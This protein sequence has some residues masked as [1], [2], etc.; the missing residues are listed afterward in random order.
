MVVAFNDTPWGFLEVSRRYVLS[1]CKALYQI[2]VQF[3]ESF[4]EA[5]PINPL[6]ALSIPGLAFSTWRTVQLPKLHNDNL[7]VYDLSQTLGNHFRDAYCGGI[8]DVSL[9]TTPEGILPSL[10]S[11]GLT[12]G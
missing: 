1:D 2:I 8:V 7:E 12:Y 5:F 4:R 10:K 11:P 3:F 6:K 9:A